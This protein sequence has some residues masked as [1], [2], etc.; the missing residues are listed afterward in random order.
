MGDKTALAVIDTQVGMF[1]TSGL[2][3]VPEGERLPA[4]ISFGNP[5]EA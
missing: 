2:P 3:P 5:V 4:E 1:G